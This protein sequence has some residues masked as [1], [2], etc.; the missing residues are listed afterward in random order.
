[1]RIGAIPYIVACI[2]WVHLAFSQV[3]QPNRFEVEMKTYDDNFDLINGGKD[4]LLLLRQTG[5]RSKKGDRMFEVMHLDTAL[6]VQWQQFL[7]I[8]KFW[9]YKGYDYFDGNFYVLFK[10]TKGG[11]RDLKILQLNLQSGDTAQYTISNLVHIEL[12]EFEVTRNAALLGGYYNFTPLVIHF[13]FDSK[14]SRVLPGIFQ[15]KAQLVHLK[16][17]ETQDTFLVIVS[18]KTFDKRKTLSVKKYNSD[19]DLIDNTRLRPEVDKG[20]LHGRAAAFDRNVSLI[21]GTY[22]NRRSFHS[23]GIFIAAIQENDDQNL[24]Y[25]SYADFEN[26][27]NYMKAKRRKR[28]KARI[29]RKKVRGKKAKF[30]YRLLVHDIVDEGDEYVMIGEAYY[31]KYNSTGSLP[32]VSTTIPNEFGTYFAGFRYTHAVVIGFDKQGN[33]LWDNSFQ[34]EDVLTYN[35]DQFVHADVQ[36]DKIVLLYMYDNEIRTKIIVGHE[37]VEG[38]SYDPIQL[39]FDDDQLRDDDTRIGGLEDWYGNKFYAYGTQRIKNLND[40]GVKLN[41]RVFFIN[42]IYYR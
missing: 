12:T 40:P 13:S 33:I 18:E 37:I 38:K 22:S 6:N 11:S 31:P 36:E 16:V 42:K 19:G 1:M 28:V 25:Y 15:P 2:F 30:N 24:K 7:Y 10:F 14:K 39:T 26:F 29:E 23:R 9:E 34:I 27:F 8:N 20:L 21:S 5:A 35:L 41:R 4:G 32:V 17:H 3:A